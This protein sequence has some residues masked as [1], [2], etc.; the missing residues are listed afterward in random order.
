[1][2]D[3]PTING[4]GRKA[5][6][7]IQMLLGGLAVLNTLGLLVVVPL[8]AWVLSTVMEHDREI[9]ANKAN[10]FTAADGAAL[11]TRVA[12]NEDT[13]ANGVPPKWFISKVENIEATTNDVNKR[14]TRIELLLEKRP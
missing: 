8:C 6:G 13:L 11:T 9:T 4:N 3:N 10:R 7:I 1:M 12:R 5:M 2:S 14:L